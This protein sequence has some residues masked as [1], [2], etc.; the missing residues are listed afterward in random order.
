VYEYSK[1]LISGTVRL[2]AEHVVAKQSAARAPSDFP[3]FIF[4]DGAVVQEMTG[5]DTRRTSLHFYINRSRFIPQV[6][7]N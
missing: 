5:V 6:L 1:G 7:S 4:F 3:S 2:N